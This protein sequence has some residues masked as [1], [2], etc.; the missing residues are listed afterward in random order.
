MKEE[1]PD[2][3]IVLQSGNPDNRAVADAQDA[4]FLLKGSPSMLRELRDHLTEHL[5]FGDFVFR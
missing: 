1:R 5:F 2:L 4:G 3:S